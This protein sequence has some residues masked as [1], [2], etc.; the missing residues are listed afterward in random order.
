MHV[1]IVV[2][3]GVRN[4]LWLGRIEPG[5]QLKLLNFNIHYGKNY[6][7][8]YDP[9]EVRR[10]G[11]LGLHLPAEPGRLLA[12]RPTAR[13]L[14]CTAPEKLNWAREFNQTYNADK[15]TKTEHAI[16]SMKQL[17]WQLRMEFWAV[18][19]TLLGKLMMTT[20]RYR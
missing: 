8:I 19:G 4:F 3:Y 5:D 11:N 17:M 16:V 10:H 20:M 2:V 1:H 18:C 6:E 12:Q 14:N 9:I 7:E 13:Y 15:V